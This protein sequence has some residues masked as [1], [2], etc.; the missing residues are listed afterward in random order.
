[1]SSEL[2]LPESLGTRKCYDCGA[3]P[4]NDERFWERF[5]EY[6][7]EIVAV[8]CCDSCMESIQ[9]GGLVKPIDGMV[10]SAIESAS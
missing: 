1:M 6:F 4:E 9:E 8:P 7:G 2:L 10:G 5:V 3:E